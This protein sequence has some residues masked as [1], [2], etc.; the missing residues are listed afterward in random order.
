MTSYRVSC[1][2]WEKPPIERSVSGEELSCLE[3]TKSTFLIIRNT[4][5]KRKSRH[6][7]LTVVISG[8][9]FYKKVKKTLRSVTASYR[10]YKLSNFIRQIFVLYCCCTKIIRSH[11]EQVFDI[12][13]SCLKMRI[14]SRAE[15]K[16]IL[17]RWVDCR[18]RW[19]FQT[20][21]S[22]QNQSFW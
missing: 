14:V 12:C 16:K 15:I 2:P 22:L 6:Q 18:Q 17:F 21:E 19:L 7:N 5:F 9:A 11:A 1:W 20:W 3:L 13:H 4:H 10:L 8:H